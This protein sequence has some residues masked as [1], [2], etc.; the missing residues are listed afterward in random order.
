METAE[1]RHNKL[2]WF[3][4]IIFI[5]I[6]FTIFLALVLLQV[7]G[8]N[9]LEHAKE[10]GQKIPGVSSLIVDEEE[11]AQLQIEELLNKDIENLKL[12]LETK[13]LEIKDLENSLQSK[14]N[15]IM[16]MNQEVKRLKF[17]LEALIEEQQEQKTSNKEMTKL[18]EIM[19]PKKAASILPNLTDE[20]A[21]KILSSLKPDK[22]AAIFERMTPEEAARFTK[23]LSN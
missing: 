13:E 8:I 9:V 16:S 17:D 4:F 12:K 10:I 21:A 11:K 18:Y 23:L 20:E 2:Q 5:P 15:E 1:K 22:L 19:S 6:L 3:L 7:G 14:E